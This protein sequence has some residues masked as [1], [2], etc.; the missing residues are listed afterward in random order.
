[1]AA[2]RG[3]DA[4]VTEVAS[5]TR[6]A[7]QVAH[8][9]QAIADRRSRLVSRHL[10]GGEEEPSQHLGGIGSDYAALALALDNLEKRAAHLLPRPAQREHGR[11]VAAD[12]E[13]TLGELT[14]QES[15]FAKRALE[16]REGLC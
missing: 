8:Y 16:P 11:L 12:P 13:P 15:A 6:S 3:A 1:M 10:G 5:P 2:R 4:T 14:R 7:Q 9:R